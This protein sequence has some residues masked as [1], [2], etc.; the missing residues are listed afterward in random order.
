MDIKT[1]HF[2]SES[3]GIFADEKYENFSFD[4]THPLGDLGRA[5]GWNPSFNPNNPLGDLNKIVGGV[6]TDTKIVEPQNKPNES[7][8]NNKTP[9]K[10]TKKWVVPVAIGGGL[11]V[12][13]IIVF[14]SFRKKS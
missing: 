3:N 6:G 1:Q 9:T 13:G 5:I 2:G 10:P 14:V 8:S 7:T 4:I 12:V 11:L